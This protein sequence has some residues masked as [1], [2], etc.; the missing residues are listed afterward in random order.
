MRI[1]ILK[2]FVLLLIDY[3]SPHGYELMKKISDLTNNIL[4]PGPG[5]IYPLLFLLEKQGLIRKI[6]DNGRKR[7]CLTDLGRKFLYSNLD[8]LKKMIEELNRII[9]I[10]LKRKEIYESNHGN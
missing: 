3:Y 5:T 4:K 8:R 10:E 2:L 7:Y 9:E 1:N 6:V